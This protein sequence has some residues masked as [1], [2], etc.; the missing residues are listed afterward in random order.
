MYIVSSLLVH[1]YFGLNISS[2]EENLHKIKRKFKGYCYVQFYLRKGLD[3]SSNMRKQ[4][5]LEFNG[6][7]RHLGVHVAKSTGHNFNL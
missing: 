4:Y 1:Y 7:K 3:R 2:Q 5:R 6:V